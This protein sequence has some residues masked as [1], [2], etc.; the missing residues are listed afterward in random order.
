MDRVII[1]TNGGNDLTRFPSK[2]IASNNDIAVRDTLKSNVNYYKKVGY[3]PYLRYS[4]DTTQLLPNQIKYIPVVYKNILP[5]TLK[6]SALL[7]LRTNNINSYTLSQAGVKIDSI[8]LN[9]VYNAKDS[10]K[11]IALSPTNIFLN[12]DTIQIKLKYNIV[13]LN[14]VHLGLNIPQTTSYTYNTFLMWQILYIRLR[15]F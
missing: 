15:V 5:N 1:N 8:F 7:D 6:D 9:N 12:T 3:F 11:K 2:N 4:N 13:P 10:F 14:V